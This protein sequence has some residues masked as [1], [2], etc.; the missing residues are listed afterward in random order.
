MDQVF[1]IQHLFEHV[2]DFLPYC[3]LRFCCRV[4]KKWNRLFSSFIEKQYRVILKKMTL[5]VT[6]ECIKYSLD[7][8]HSKTIYSKDMIELHFN[9][10]LLSVHDCKP[11]YIEV[12]FNHKM[13][14]SYNDSV[15]FL[16]GYN[17]GEFIEQDEEK[18]TISYCLLY[19]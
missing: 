3:E 1:E 19:K 18:M 10:E 16:S 11:T 6:N 13:G 17:T 9:R 15:C 4:S 12:M 8:D 2:F 7:V 5:L 14:N